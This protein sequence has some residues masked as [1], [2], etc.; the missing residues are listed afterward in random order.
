MAG[1]PRFDFYSRDWIVG[2][3]GLSLEASGAY[4]Q[5]LARM[6]DEARPLPFDLPFLARRIGVHWRSLKNAIAEL[7]ERGKIIIRNGFLT[8]DRFE[9]RDEPLALSDR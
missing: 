4:I 3:E 1:M 2:T 8:N 6:Y 5:L 7:I 9:T